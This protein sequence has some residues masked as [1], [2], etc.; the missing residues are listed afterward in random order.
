MRVKLMAVVALALLLAVAGDA[1]ARGRKG[2]C[3][4]GGCHSGGCGVYLP[5]YSSPYTTG[6]YYG[7]PVYSS[8]GSTLTETPALVGATTLTVTDSTGR[9]IYLIPTGRT[10]NGQPTYYQST[11]KP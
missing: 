3:G 7:G 4:K 2:G 9:T 8:L 1:E 10:F 11:T 6:Y 5:Y